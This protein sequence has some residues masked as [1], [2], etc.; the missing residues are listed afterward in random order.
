M[1]RPA[2]GRPPAAET[3]PSE[4]PGAGSSQRGGVGRAGAAAGER[5]GGAGAARSEGSPLASDKSDVLQD[6]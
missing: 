1:T 3:L 2:S 5:R 6:P 4:E